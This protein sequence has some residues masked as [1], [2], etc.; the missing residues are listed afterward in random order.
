MVNIYMDYCLVL[1]TP[2]LCLFLVNAHNL[3][4]E[5][6][7]PNVKYMNDL[8]A[9]NGCCSENIAA[10]SQNT[11]KDKT[12][13]EIMKRLSSRIK[14]RPTRIMKRSFSS[15]KFRPTSMLKGIVTASVYG[16]VKCQSLETR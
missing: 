8:L 12:I 13:S 14:I 1:S 16:V 5:N 10:L 9:L 6:T 11:E 15:I 7:W 4:E 3:I 2:F